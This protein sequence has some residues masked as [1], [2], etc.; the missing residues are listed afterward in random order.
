MLRGECIALPEEAAAGAAEFMRAGRVLVEARMA[1]WALL[2]APL[3]WWLRRTVTPP[4]VETGSLEVEAE[5]STDWL[6][7]AVE[8]LVRSVLVKLSG[9]STSTGR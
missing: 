3:S 8:N 5:K 9:V 7:E 2:T 4:L 6:T 1:E